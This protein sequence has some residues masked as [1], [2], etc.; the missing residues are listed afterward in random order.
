MMMEKAKNKLR[1]ALYE[2][3]SKME[4]KARERPEK[5]II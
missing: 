2:I 4:A 3:L 5:A 1:N